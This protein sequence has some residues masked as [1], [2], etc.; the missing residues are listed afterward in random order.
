MNRSD[1][2]TAEA[3]AA[4]VRSEI[5]EQ[6]AE[7]ISEHLDSCTHCEET[8]V[9]LEREGDT[10]AL[11]LRQ[12]VNA[13][14]DQPDAG[15]EQMLRELKQCVAPRREVSQEA[16]LPLRQLRDY[17][18]LKTIGSGGMGTVYQAEHVRLHQMVALKVL[19]P[20]RFD[21]PQA[22]ARFE[23]EM[24]AVGQ[25]SHKNIVR[26][27][28]AGVENGRHYLAMEYLEGMTLSDLVRQRGPIPISAA[29][30]IISQ[31]AQGLQYAHERGLVHR[32]IKPANL[33]LAI[34]DRPSAGETN[35]LNVTVKIL[36]FGLARLR[37]L[38]AE[39]D[40]ELTTTGLIV[41]TIDYM[42]PEQG[43]DTH[44]SDI[45]SDIYSL[46]A[47]F[48][49]LLTGCAPLE[50]ADRNTP[51]KRLAALETADP[52]PVEEVRDGIPAKLAA[53]V[54]RMLAKSPDERYAT[55]AEVA[56]ALQPF[57]AGAD[58]SELLKKPKA[59]STKK[60]RSA[61]VSP[62]VAKTE[63]I[64]PDSTT[65]EEKQ[66][67]KRIGRRR[68]MCLFAI[69]LIVGA[70]VI[71]APTV[72]LIV[73]NQG[74]IVVETDG[75]NIELIVKNSQ[76]AII[77]PQLKRGLTL[78]VGDYELDVKI[79]KDGKTRSV[80]RSVSLS[81]G[82]Q[83]VV[84]ADW[85]DAEQPASLAPPR[86]QPPKQAQPSKQIAQDKKSLTKPIPISQPAA[87]AGVV[88]PIEGISWRPGPA[89]PHLPGAI[90]QPAPIPGIESWQILPQL[91][92]AGQ[93]NW[94]S[95]QGTYLVV[96]S[97][98]NAPFAW[99][100]HRGQGRIVG[101][102]P[103]RH[104]ALG[105]VFSPDEQRLVAMHNNEN[106]SDISVYAIDGRL[107]HRW[108]HVL[109]KP[110]ADTF[111]DWS[112]DGERILL[113]GQKTTECRSPDGEPV[114]GFQPPAL[115]ATAGYARFSPD[116][117]HFACLDR[118]VVRVYERS[119]G[120]SVVE[121]RDAET[122]VYQHGGLMWHPSGSQ[123]WSWH[124]GSQGNYER[125]WTLDGKS[126]KLPPYKN[127]QHR[128]VAFSPNGKLLLSND[129]EI[130]DLTGKTLARLSLPKRVQGLG[131]IAR[132]TEAERIIAHFPF[133]PYEALEFN[134]DGKIMATAR[135]PHPLP[136]QAATWRNQADEL[137][138]LF[139][140]HYGSPRLRL[141]TWDTEGQGE[142]RLSPI[143][144]T[145]ETHATWNAQREGWTLSGVAGQ[146][147]IDKAGRQIASRQP[148]TGAP[149]SVAAW[150][151]DGKLLATAQGKQ[152][153][154]FQVVLRQ[155][156]DVVSRLKGH[157]QPISGMVWCSAGTHLAAWDTDEVVYLWEI[158]NE[159]EIARI[160]AH[161]LGG[162]YADPI[163]H[164]P[165]WNPDG[166]YLTVPTQEGL[167]IAA[168]D[169]S[170]PIKIKFAGRQPFA[171][172][173]DNRSLLA[174]N[175]LYSLTGEVIRQQTD[176]TSTAETL[177]WSGGD[178]GLLSILDRQLQLRTA[179]DGKPVT[180]ALPPRGADEMFHPVSLIGDAAAGAQSISASG[181]YAGLI[182]NR[183]ASPGWGPRGG[184]LALIDLK[185]QK[186]TWLSIAFSDGQRVV[187][188]ASGQVLHAPAQTDR[189]LTYVV[190][191]PN[192]RILPLTQ[193]Q[194]AARTGLSAEQR[195]LQRVLDFGGRLRVSDA[196]KW[197]YAANLA[198]ASA[199]PAASA[200]TGIEL[201]GPSNRP[202][203]ILVGLRQLPALRELKLSQTEIEE[204]LSA[205]LPEKLVE[206]DVSGTG[207][208]DQFLEEC[209]RLREL[210][211]LNVTGTRVTET[212]V[213][214]FK[215][216]VPA[217]EIIR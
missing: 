117:K 125:L 40:E 22:A 66:P 20:H 86:E 70:S 52:L 39:D 202:V 21:D 11:R 136:I 48:Y 128:T 56:E 95:P 113:F 101:L 207:I 112:P 137:V 144:L 67:S 23:R 6:N 10:L 58:L 158:S 97:D 170:T 41:G 29:C 167:T 17:K 182:V 107:L 208:D 76:G 91:P 157:S 169:D 115:G 194:F 84:K 53:I 204:G 68:W 9:G 174:G 25:L 51:L 186:L 192:G 81:R 3:L 145:A 69:L 89:D 62:N 149:F 2:P 19:A 5:S 163:P 54:A 138:G 80:K 209:Q 200:V 83:Q 181:R 171:W 34:N 109:G 179:L 61:A 148:E 103:V 104:R 152:P 57:T 155:D 77:D 193:R 215:A 190:R 44:E 203:E 94:L 45:R 119:G 183:K 49:K 32:D 31:A 161:R 213:A 196:D 172:N 164:S 96:W 36:D 129:G 35:P 135:F 154:T 8:V 93:H 105:I 160:K 141:F 46:G 37:N 14:A 75:D 188:D 165:T 98:L 28:D 187:L 120:E 74:A 99:I 7:Q 87:N 114:S 116:G 55:P 156:A 212:G 33:M 79:K 159:R 88:K 102:I 16:A 126:Q 205:F 131:L 134:S 26:A 199:L 71:Y 106:T 198:D 43:A 146:L 121:L 108:E 122:Q 59:S 168:T 150:S 177:A 216:A 206:L 123:I 60:R 92:Y 217:C 72:K 142:S 130:R 110:A 27:T 175:T 189:Y 133:Q 173:P 4:Y 180:V 63:D 185:Q 82:E 214:A 13:D 197:L 124:T 147:E 42:A 143:A 100:I 162:T 178:G 12:A 111:A 90:A 64:G 38:S 201:T 139:R 47:T 151:P 127:P 65:T 211:R 50:K 195:L 15:L 153:G 140:Q 118:G 210:Q 184:E 176:D 73:A 166:R 18:I 132:W 1:C 85:A 24:Q 191:Y 30:A 78:P